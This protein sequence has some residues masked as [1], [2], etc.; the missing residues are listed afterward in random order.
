[1]HTIVAA[2]GSETG[3]VACSTR[4]AGGFHLSFATE[5]DL[6]VRALSIASTVCL[7]QQRTTKGSI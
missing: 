3:E 5:A 2:D 7:I 6:P 1:M 4:G